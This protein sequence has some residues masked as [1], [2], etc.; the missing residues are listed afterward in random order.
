MHLDVKITLLYISHENG[1]DYSVDCHEVIR[2]ASFVGP[3][4]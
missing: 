1:T 3:A 4:R 2:R